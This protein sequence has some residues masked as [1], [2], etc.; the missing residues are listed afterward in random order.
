MVRMYLSDVAGND[1]GSL[2]LLAEYREA[3]GRES[4]G[5]QVRYSDSKTFRTLC[6]YSQNPQERLLSN[7][8]E[9]VRPF[10]I[11]I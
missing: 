2:F 9:A 4:E 3:E 6:T 8:A 7:I 10:I 1:K 11:F 5:Y